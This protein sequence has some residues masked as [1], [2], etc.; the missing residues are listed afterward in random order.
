MSLVLTHNGAEVDLGAAHCEL[1]SLTQS[2]LAPWSLTLRRAI[3]FDEPTDW[4]NED[5][6]ELERD[7]TPV[8]V[9]TIKSSERI[10]SADAEHIAYTCVGLRGLADGI[11]FQRL[12]GGTATARVVYNCPIEEEVEEAGYVAI[13][14]T[15]A[16]VGQILAD[17]LD[18]LAPALAGVIGDGTPGSGYVAAELDALAIVPPKTVLNGT[19][20]DAAIRTVLRHAP[21][22]GYA[23]DPA[24]RHARFVDFRTLEARSVAGVGDRVL[25]HELDFA[26]AGCYSACTVQ[27]TYELVDMCEPLEPAWDPAFE[28][29]WT[30]D[31]AGKFPDTYGQVW[32]LYESPTVG[33]LGCALM[34][35]RFVGNGDIVA[36]VT[37]EEALT[38]ST[39]AVTATV[40]DD[41][42][43]MLKAYARMWSTGLKRYVPAIVRA[44]FTYRT[45]RVA[46]RYPE[47]GHTGTAHTRRG[48]ERERLLIDEERGRKIVRG[49]VDRV[50][51]PTVF[52]TYYEFLAKDQVAGKP[53]VFDD[54]GVE[55][56]IVHNG[57]GY[58]ALD[59]APAVP[60]AEGHTYSIIV[61]DDTRKEFEGGTLSIL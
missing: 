27:G 34:P 1:G 12:V 3:A 31:K 35:Q 15:R 25:S 2:F 37:I 57:H 43:V 56:T 18:T 17:I 49:S 30:G 52:Q 7:G 23:I 41:A 32:R 14:G 51:T 55:Y 48:L 42:R 24:T 13:A 33:G 22:F 4:Q 39:F 54:N 8:F 60:L 59:Q 20:A 47:A 16:T 44:R 53:I 58:F 28:A 61:Q 29:D 11:P 45:E 46:G 5:A 21:D 50:I 6:I 26:T 40:V 9:G 19:S 36:I 38:T 10:A